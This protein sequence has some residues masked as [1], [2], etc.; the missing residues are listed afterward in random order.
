MF[1]SS[2]PNILLLTVD[3]W[4]ASLFGFAGHR[5]I[6]TPTF[7]QLSRLGVTFS[8]AYS[9]SPICIPARRSMMT[10][11]SPRA[12][13]DRSFSAELEMPNVS[14]LADAF[15]GAGYQTRAIGKLHVFPQRD[16]IGF[17]EV[18]LAEEGRV[19]LGAVDDYDIYLAEAGHAGMQF[20]HGIS[21]NG[22][23][24]RTWHLNEE[25]HVTNWLTRQACREIKRRD[26][27]KPNFWHLSYTHPH[28]PLIPLAAYENLY[29]RDEID[30]PIESNWSQAPSLPS[31]LRLAHAYWP[32]KYSAKR[33]KQIRRAYYALCTHIDHQVRIVIG[34]LRE[35]GLLNDTVIMFTADHGDMLGDHGL[36][37]KRFFYEGSSNVP[38]IL[39]GAA[40]DTRLPAGTQDSRLT[41]LQDVM[42]TLLDIAGIQIP[43]SVEGTSMLSDKTRSHLY[44]ECGEDNSATRMIH[45][46]RM[47]LIWYPSGN[48]VQ[49]F[50]LDTDPNETNDLSAHSDHV[51]MMASLTAKL[52]DHLYGSDLKWVRDGR[53]IGYDPPSLILKADRGLTGQRGIHYPQPPITSA[54]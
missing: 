10:G 19:G 43:A 30:A 46:G 2:K 31:A 37:A 35:E 47:K 53:L 11:L 7:D 41:C 9:E 21:N 6:Q 42:P 23:E 29:T 49:L 17:D 27:T 24:H 5:S 3:Q 34:T 16:R 18:I 15:K 48:C 44:G 39:V 28:P 32:Q 51:D 14:T 52:I 4:A 26:P 13:G 1:S 40:S 12:H 45:D 36:W 50:D 20:S 25:F 8:N 38:M 54:G 22:Y 33:L